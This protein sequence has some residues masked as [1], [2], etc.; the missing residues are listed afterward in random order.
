[1]DPHSIKIEIEDVDKGEMAMDT[2]ISPIA[3]IE[4]SLTIE[5]NISFLLKQ[6]L[7]AQL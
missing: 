5:V 2:E 4:I 1:M 7:Q 3:E 6:K